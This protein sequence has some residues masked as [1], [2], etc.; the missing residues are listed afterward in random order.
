MLRRV[1][2]IVVMVLAWCVIIAYMLYASHLAKRERSEQLVQEVVVTIVDSTATRQF[3]SSADILRKLKSAGFRFEKQPIESVDVV[4]ATNYLL[5]SGYIS[6]VDMYVTS[7]GRMVVDIDQ[8]EPFVR[9]MATGYNSYIT[10]EGHIFRAPRGSA[11]HTAVITGNLRPLFA[12]GYEGSIE[13]HYRGVME[14]QNHRLQQLASERSK[15][16]HEER[17]CVERI[18]ELKNSRRRKFFEKKSNYEQRLKGVEMSIVESAAQSR[19][20]RAQRQGVERKQ[21]EVESKRQRLAQR[22][23]DFCALMDFVTETESD[24][25]WGAEI[26]QYVADT[27]SQGEICLRL[28][29]RSGDFTIEFGTLATA[30]DKLDKLHK[31]YDD[32]LSNMGWERFSKIDVRYNNQVIC[33]E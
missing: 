15:L 27:T 18:K 7:S 2:S 28:I 31:F 17:K 10:T 29:P 3:S 20:F 11:Y 26:V 23:N 5:K 25:F 4:S 30:A 32:G 12:P 16:R 33:T 9:F 6:D 8:H 1:L 14:E 22:Y 19:K 13:S 21:M 24:D